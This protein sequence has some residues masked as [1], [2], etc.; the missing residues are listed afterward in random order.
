M[1]NTV[2]SKYPAPAKM[3]F[4]VVPTQPAAEPAK[5]RPKTSTVNQPSATTGDTGERQINQRDQI[6]LA[7]EVELAT[8]HAAATPKTIEWHGDGAAIRSV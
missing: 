2:A 6:P 8:A 7:A 4:D 3:I 1:T 5:L